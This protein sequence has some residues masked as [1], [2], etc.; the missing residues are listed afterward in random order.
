MDTQQQLIELKRAMKETMELCLFEYYRSVYLYLSG[1]S[2]K[3][4][5]KIVGHTGKTISGHVSAYRKKGL[6]GLIP[7]RSSGRPRRLTPQQESTLA[8][9]VSTKLPSNVELSKFANWTLELMVFYTQRE[10]NVSY[11]IRG[12]SILMERLGLTCT[13]PTY[14]LTNADSQKQRI[15]GQETFPN[16]KKAD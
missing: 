13:R 3:E 15:F 14:T 4:V 1:Y 12:M 2:M 6:I 16:L 9:V 8:E 10:W 11:S 5:A 7:G